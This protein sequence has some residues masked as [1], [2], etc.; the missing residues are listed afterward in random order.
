[1]MT[2]V[3]LEELGFNVARPMIQNCDNNSAVMTY[4]T[5]QPEWRSPTLA[6]KYWH[7]R[8]YVDNDDMKVIYVNTKD[9]NSDIHTKWLP[10]ADHLRHARW[11]G[12]YD[13][14]GTVEG[15]CGGAPVAW[16][17]LAISLRNRP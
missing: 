8:D 9:N 17:G 3:F 12:L 6:T 4:N 5:E 13:P 7:S 15:E 14:D 1:M 16:V 11:L 10:N 2:T